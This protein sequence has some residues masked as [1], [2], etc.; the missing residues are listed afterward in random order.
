MCKTTLI[1]ISLLVLLMGVAGVIPGWELAT[2]PTWHAIAKIIVGA[3]GL[4]VAFSD[5][6]KGA[7]STTSPEEKTPE[8][9]PETPSETPPETPQT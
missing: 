3:I 1:I 7:M 6:E 9:P 2:E 4:I 5:K 8:T